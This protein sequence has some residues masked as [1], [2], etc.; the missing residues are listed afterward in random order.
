[1]LECVVNVSEG[2]DRAVIAALAAAGGRCLLDVHT[3]PHHHRSVLTLAGDGVEDAARAVA[4]EAVARLD[5]RAHRGVHP[6]LGVVDVVPF[7]PLEGSTIDDALA[8]RDRFLGWAAVELALPGFAYGPE[9]SLPDVRRTAFGALAPSAGPAA[10][11]PTAGAVCVGARPV[12]VAYNV[13]LADGVGVDEARRVAAS[14]RGAGGGAV[15]AVRALGLDVGGRA[16]VSMNLVDPLRLGPAPA[17]DAVRALVAVDSAE[18]VG[19][20]PAAVLDRVPEERWGELDLGRS[21][22][23]ESRLAERGRPE[24]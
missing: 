4:A 13:W 7:V 17:Y 16:Q 20:L 6:R 22:T 1:V 11:H 8:A 18:L 23:I 3:D 10:P 21:R 19:L 9:R 5:L 2:R 15:R 14:V 12:L 24:A